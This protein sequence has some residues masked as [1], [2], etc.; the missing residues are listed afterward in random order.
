M[1]KLRQ[2]ENDRIRELISDDLFVEWRLVR[3]EELN[4]YW[5]DFIRRNPGYSDALDA[6]SR[7]VDSVRI[8]ERH[9]PPGIRIALYE[10]IAGRLRRRRFDMY[11]AILSVSATAAILVMAA[12]F[13][14]FVL[15]DTPD[16]NVAVQEITT[17]RYANEN[18]L[19]I[20]DGKVVELENVEEAITIDAE[21]AIAVTGKDDI[22]ALPEP[23]KDALSRIVVPAG[24]R[25]SMTLSDGS[26]IWLNSCTELTVP[27]RFDGR[28]REIT[29]RGEIY[30]EVAP[31]SKPFI[32]HTPD[33]NVVVHGTV[34]NI[35]VYENDGE[36]FVVLVE[37]SV[38]LNIAGGKPVRLEP[39]QI[40]LVGD[41][42]IEKRNVD[43]NEY[44]G[45]KDGILI[46]NKAPLSLILTKIGRY[47]NIAFE[48]EDG[49]E[50]MRR[51]YS[52][53]LFLTGNI[54]SM[55]SSVSAI[56]STRYAIRQDTIHLMKP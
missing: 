5:A 31:G 42:G 53:K 28:T 2:K 49:P 54:D 15:N 45:W 9:V 37:G 3:S 55:M 29:V 4:A 14:K 33:F 21:G 34:F 39:N 48:A 24:R 40:A 18:I 32:V 30:A 11:A 25:S 16:K 36:K 19:L 47:Y 44:I 8:N 22:I 6:A 1:D 50:L 27:N 43:V 17:D 51:R 10:K 46:F 35:S 52:G 41:A 20:T 56:T 7:M 12:I 13:G 26:K 23:A 38:S